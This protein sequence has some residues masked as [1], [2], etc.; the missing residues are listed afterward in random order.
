M[1]DYEKLT[2]NETPIITVTG[3]AYWDIGH[4]PKNQSNRRKNLSRHISV[5][6]MLSKILH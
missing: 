5:N 1:S 4:A 2:W 6:K 3:K